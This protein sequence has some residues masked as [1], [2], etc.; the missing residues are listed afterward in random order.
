MAAERF[1]QAIEI[2]P[3]SAGAWN[4]LGVV[5]S[6]IGQVDEAIRS[7]RQTLELDPE[8]IDA[9]YNLA[10]ALEQQGQAQAAVPHWKL[11]LKYDPAGRWADYARKQVNRSQR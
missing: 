5:L 9:H 8:F 6:E 3:Q 11:Y 7:F 1:R 2:D 10:D 4:N